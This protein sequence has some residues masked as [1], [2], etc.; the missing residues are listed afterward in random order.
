MSTNLAPC[1]AS[2]ARKI[3]DPMLRREWFVAARASDLSEGGVLAA[4]VLGEDLVLWRQ[5]GRVMAWRDLCIH[6]GAKLSLGKVVDG[7]LQC[8]YHGWRYAPDARCTRIPA[9]MQRAIPGKA[10][11]FPVHALERYDAIWVCLAE[12]PAGPLPAFHGWAAEGARYLASG[13]RLAAKATRV[14]ENYLDFSHLPFL[15]A[16][17]LGDPDKPHVEDYEVEDTPDGLIAR[18]LKI[19]Q[20]D[21]DGTGVGDYRTYDYFC[22][23]PLIAG[24]SKEHVTSILAATPV[25]EDTTVAWL[26]GPVNPS[27]GMSDEQIIAWSCLIITQD[28]AAV[29]SQRPELLP[30]DLQEELHLACDKLAI[31]YRRSLRRAGL[32]YGVS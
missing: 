3:D 11:A 23:R 27:R 28:A 14:I 19:Y 12:E 17:Y 18:G 21:P 13:H 8:P 6:R 20:P 1:P 29:E 16:G 25:D 15:H 5:D 4:R 31:A 7:C 22:Y 24:F 10:R 30:L 26:I 32:V 9:Q 2:S